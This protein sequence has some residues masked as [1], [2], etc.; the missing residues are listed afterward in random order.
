MALD[1]PR[2]FIQWVEVLCKQKDFDLD[3]F[4]SAELAN[5]N[6]LGAQKRDRSSPKRLF[7]RP[8][9]K[10][11]CLYDFGPESEVGGLYNLVGESSE[12]L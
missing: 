2:K 5:E 8:I 10:L 7:G 1:H 4:C 9:S 6:L 12:K 11:K 3:D